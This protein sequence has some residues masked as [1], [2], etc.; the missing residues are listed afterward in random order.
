MIT[1]PIADF[2]TRIRNASRVHKKTVAARSSNMLKAIAQVL[3]SKRFIESF[4]ENTLDNHAELTVTLRSDREPLELKRISKP[5][6]RIYVGHKDIKKVRNGLGI[7]LISTSS[8]IITG[9]EAKEKKVGG[10]YLL[11]VY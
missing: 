11:E 8:G 5:G 4:A 7:A 6:Q 2:I 9:E 1:D 3:A 10:E